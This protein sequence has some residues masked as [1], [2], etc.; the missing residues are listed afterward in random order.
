[1]IQFDLN[2]KTTALLIVDMQNDFVKEGA[3]MHVPAALRIVPRLREL[4][5]FCRRKGIPVIYTAHMHSRDG[6]DMGL[7]D[8][9]W[10]PIR[11]RMALIEGTEGVEIYPEI[12]PKE[13]EAVVRKHR[14]SGFY[15]TDLE[16]RLCNMGID[17]VVISGTVTNM[18]CESTARDAQ[19]RDFKVIF[20][21]DTTAPMDIPGM[22][23]EEVQKAT[24]HSLA[25]SIGQVM[26]S[27]ELMDK[28]G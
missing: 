24:C 1:M 21:S 28:L 9:F 4:L 25:A 2:P 11:N 13:G 6:S 27:Q 20:L 26:T 22:S 18:C 12:A 8:D 7:M 23:A 16:I 17:T 5:E 3:P 10:T 19:F 14:Y 15:G